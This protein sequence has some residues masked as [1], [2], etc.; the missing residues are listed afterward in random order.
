MQVTDRY[1]LD[2]FEL[3]EKD[4]HNAKYISIVILAKG[5]TALA[6]SEAVGLSR[7]LC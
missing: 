6:I 4:A 3:A 5:Y 7:W 1:T 2:H